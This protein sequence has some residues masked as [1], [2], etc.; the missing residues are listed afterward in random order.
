[1]L[2]AELAALDAEAIVEE[3]LPA[4]L[5]DDAARAR[6]PTEKLAIFRGLFRGRPDI[7]PTRFVSREGKPGYAPAC[8]NKFVRGICE[9]PKVKCGECTNQAFLPVDDAA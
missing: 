4:M 5:V 9:L 3:S 2:L 7:Y 8:A 1:M 6:L